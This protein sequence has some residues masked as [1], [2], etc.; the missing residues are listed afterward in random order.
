MIWLIHESHWII[1][2]W[3]HVG[4][5]CFRFQL[6]KWIRCQR[7][8]DYVKKNSRDVDAVFLRNERIFCV[9]EMLWI[10]A[11]SSQKK[12]IYLVIPCSTNQHTIYAQQTFKNVITMKLIIG[13]SINSRFVNQSPDVIFMF[14]ELSCNC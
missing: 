6:E 7:E 4:Y 14:N 1:I 12:I 11:F 5:G 8:I 10:V 13:E 3:P 9:F 2:I